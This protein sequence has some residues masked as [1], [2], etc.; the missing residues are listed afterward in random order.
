VS[1]S[2]FGKVVLVERCMETIE[3]KLVRLSN[4]NHMPRAWLWKAL[5]TKR[6]RKLTPITKVWGCSH[7][8]KFRLGCWSFHRRSHHPRCRFRPGNKVSKRPSRKCTSWDCRPFGSRFGMPSYRQY[9]LRWP[10]SQV[11]NSANLLEMI[12]ASSLPW[13]MVE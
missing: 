13:H 7:R 5:A 9:I 1:S 11:C 4:T 2:V 6:Q 3:Q 12:L 8:R 10:C